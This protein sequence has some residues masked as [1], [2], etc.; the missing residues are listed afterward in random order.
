MHCPQ[1]KQRAI[2]F[3]SWASGN[4]WIRYKCPHCGAALKVSRRT[5]KTVII[6]FLVCLPLI[7]F[8]LPFVDSHFENETVRML[9][10]LGIIAIL[11]TPGAFWDW[12][13]GYYAPQ[14]PPPPKSSAD[15]RV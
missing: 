15:N 14:N 13:S 12:K 5:M 1:C 9:L 7:F 11:L 2:S 3:V 4:R 10:S 6:S 8:I